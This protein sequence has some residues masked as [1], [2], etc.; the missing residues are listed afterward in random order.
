MILLNCQATLYYSNRVVMYWRND[1]V[2][3]STKYKHALTDKILSLKSNM[4]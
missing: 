4:G 1:T 2:L 3:N